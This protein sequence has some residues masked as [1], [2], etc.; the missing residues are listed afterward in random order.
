MKT[1]TKL[2]E[3]SISDKKNSVKK[4]ANHFIN[5]Y[6]DDIKYDIDSITGDVIHEWYMQ[7]FSK[8]KELGRDDLDS[9]ENEIFNSL[10]LNESDSITTIKD[11][12]INSLKNGKS[13]SMVLGIY[14]GDFKVADINKAVK[15]LIDSG[16]VSFKSSTMGY[17]I[18]DSSEYGIGNALKNKSFSLK[19]LKK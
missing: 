12:I 3:S 9:V 1:I 15:S 4:A 10:S 2:Y 7:S 8:F 14:D 18:T 13:G 17:Y 6:K 5:L 16:E 19:L 11:K